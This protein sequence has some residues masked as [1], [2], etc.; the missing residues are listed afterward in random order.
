MS[1]SNYHFIVN[2]TA[3][4]GAGYR[5]WKTVEPILAEE[6]IVYS[7]YFPK[8]V[9]ETEVLT[10]QLTRSSGEDCHL[11]ILGG[12]GTLNAVLQGIECF[13]HTGISCIRTGSGNDFARN[14]HITKDVR[15]ALFNILHHPKE[16]TLDYGELYLQRDDTDAGERRRFIISSGVGYDADICEEVSRSR[17]KSIMNRIHMGKLVYV[18]IGIKQILTRQSGK[19]LIRIDDKE[20]IKISGM[21]FT[22]AMIH[23]CEGGGVPFCPQ[24]DP[25]DGKFDICLVKN[26][27]KWKLF[28][29][30]MLVY[31]KKHYL[32]RE[33]TGFR[34]RKLTIKTENPEW[35]H[36]DGETPC[37][38]RRL[39]LECKTGLRIFL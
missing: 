37:Q 16:I 5:T 24:A 30:V 23:A 6:N 3:S 22:V 13:E 9:R 11:I 36:M 31:I 4:S 38:I 17:L 28:L 21:F 19:A 10:R 12:D 39:T 8:D 2:S 27:P 20:P 1:M 14:M 25:T 26:M 34:G 29:A 32:L 35:F 33:V 18:L 7:V 15:K